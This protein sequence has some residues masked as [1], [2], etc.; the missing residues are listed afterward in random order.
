MR[1]EQATG[2]TMVC[3]AH[4]LLRP[5][6]RTWGGVVEQTSTDLIHAFICCALAPRYGAR[7]TRDRRGA[8]ASRAR[9]TH[10]TA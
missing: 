6:S 10:A 9:G 7:T 8:A 3:C 5:W 1:W 4:G 2:G